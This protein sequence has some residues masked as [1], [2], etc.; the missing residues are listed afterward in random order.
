MGEGCENMT[1]AEV[2]ELVRSRFGT[3]DEAIVRAYEG[4]ESFRALCR[5]Y[6]VCAGA[7]V[8]LQ[9]SDSEEARLREAEYSELM[10]GLVREIQTWLGAMESTAASGSGTE[11]LRSH[12]Q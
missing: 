11:G 2:L 8:R 4:S 3:S 7:L 12:Q 10:E 6:C 1:A 9:E 5:D